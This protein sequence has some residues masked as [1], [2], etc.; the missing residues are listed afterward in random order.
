MQPHIAATTKRGGTAWKLKD[1]IWQRLKIIHDTV[2]NDKQFKQILF[3]LVIA[4]F[5][6]NCFTTFVNHMS[7]EAL[8]S[9]GRLVAETVLVLLVLRYKNSQVLERI[10]YALAIFASINSVIV[11]LQLLESAGCLNT[12]FRLITTNFWG[13]IDEVARKPGMLNGFQ[14]SSLLSFLAIA[15]LIKRKDAW[16]V[17]MMSLNV[18][19]ILFG[20]RTFLVFL[21]FLLLLNFR[22]SMGAIA[23][24]SLFVLSG[25]SCDLNWIIKVHFAEKVIPGINALVTADFNKDYSANLTV[26]QYR[27]PK[28]IKSWLLGNGVP[29]YMGISEKLPAYSGVVGGG[30]PT[31]SRWLLQSGGPAV[32]LVTLI[33]GLILS[34]IWMLPG[35]ANKLFT[36]SLILTTLKGEVVTAT[37]IFSI[38]VMYALLK[39]SAFTAPV[40][41]TSIS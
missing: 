7:A 36:I 41:R 20:A 25:S 23:A 38:L 9:A 8:R 22:L 34:R 39:P 14:N 2:K 15:F 30:D 21:P 29:R 1:C 19:P 6:W 16:S 17:L 13:V 12:P 37:L 18:F 32:I 27:E 3:G 33:I 4:F 40:K 10:F 26:H 5:V 28:D 11:I 24:F 31:I 35:L